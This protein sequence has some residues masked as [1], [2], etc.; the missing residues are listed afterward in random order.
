MKRKDQGQEEEEGCGLRYMG[1]PSQTL[2]HKVAL[3]KTEH[4]P[5]G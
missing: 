1:P 2:G 4:P 3:N 5:L